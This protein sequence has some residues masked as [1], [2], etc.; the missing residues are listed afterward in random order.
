MRPILTECMPAPAVTTAP[1]QR[2][3]KLNRSQAGPPSST[4]AGLR[5]IK[6][7]R[8]LVALASATAPEPDLVT[9]FQYDDDRA[10][11]VAAA[12]ESARSKDC[13]DGSAADEVASVRHAEKDRR[14]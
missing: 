13:A 1:A 4:V 11:A 3:R 14:N 7:H 10:A 8:S 5:A 9:T 2:A 12:P 6:Q